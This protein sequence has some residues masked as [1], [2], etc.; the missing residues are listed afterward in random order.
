MRVA[1]SIRASKLLIAAPLRISFDPKRVLKA[2][3]DHA[4]QRDVVPVGLE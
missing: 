1:S 2:L 4:H 3:F